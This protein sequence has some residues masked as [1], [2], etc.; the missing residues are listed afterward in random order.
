MFFSYHPWYGA[1]LAAVTQKANKQLK[2][3]GHQNDAPPPMATL[4]MLVVFPCVSYFGFNS[5]IHLFFL[6]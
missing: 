6:P 5:L 4:K 1:K 2:V 3:G